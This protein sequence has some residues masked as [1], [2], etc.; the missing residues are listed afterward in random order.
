MKSSA[1]AMGG[2]LRSLLVI[3]KYLRMKR[4]HFVAGL[5]VYRF[6]LSYREPLAGGFAVGDTIANHACSQIQMLEII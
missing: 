2:L 1:L 6:H 4:V 3:D 5:Q